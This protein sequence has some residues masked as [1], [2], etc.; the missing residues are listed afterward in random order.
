MC[1]TWREAEQSERPSQPPCGRAVFSSDYF[2]DR[3][4]L[5]E[6]RE[7]HSIQEIEEDDQVKPK[8]DRA[9]IDVLGDFI[10]VEHLFRNSHTHQ[11]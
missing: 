9:L 11:P 1:G 5:R 4:H 8:L 10:S 6:Q 7:H 3:S 2:L